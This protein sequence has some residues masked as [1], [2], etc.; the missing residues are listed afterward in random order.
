[1]AKLRYDDQFVAKR[2]AYRAQVVIQSI[3]IQ[4]YNNSILFIHNAS[5]V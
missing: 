3:G 1:V 4:R 5:F 2:V